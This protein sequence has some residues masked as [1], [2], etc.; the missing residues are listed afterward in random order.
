MFKLLDNK[1]TPRADGLFY[2]NIFL[3]S[4]PRLKISEVFYDNFSKMVL[5]YKTS[6][7]CFSDSNCLIG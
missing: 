6:V 4:L 2:F 1:L 3:V 5:G 7:I